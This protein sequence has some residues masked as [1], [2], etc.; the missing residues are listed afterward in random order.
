MDSIFDLPTS[1]NGNDGIWTIIDPF[2]KQAHF[3]PV[4]RII[5]AVHMAKLL[6]AHIFKHHGMPKSIVS[7]CDPRMTCLFWRALFNI[8]GKKLKFSF[9]F[10]SQTYGQSELANSRVFNTLK[11]YVVD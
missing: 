5:K 11:C 9:A 1:R 10:H 2:N 7:D 4:R 6:L 8:M 3:I